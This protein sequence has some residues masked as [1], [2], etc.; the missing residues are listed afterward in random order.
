M[1]KEVKRLYRS[2]KNKVFA[3]ICGGIGE[4]TGVD[5]VIIRLI[6]V[7]ATLLTGVL[8]GVIAYLISYL[9]IPERK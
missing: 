8:L 3:G 2:K 4:Y 9:I 5:P 1:S 7:V 6:W